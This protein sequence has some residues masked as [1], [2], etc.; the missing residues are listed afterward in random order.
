MLNIVIFGAPGSG[1]GTQSQL[2]IEKYGLHHISTGEIL[3]EEI[4]NKT[5]LG[6]I[7]DE[8]ISQGH[9]VPDQLVIDMLSNLLD[10]H[11]GV[12]GFL[13]DGFP[14]TLAQGEAL[15]VLLREKGSSVAAV[16]S[17]T[18]NEEELTQRLLKRGQDSGRSDDN[19]ETIKERLNVYRSQ[20]EPLKNYYRKNGRLFKVQGEGAVDEIFEGIMETLDHLTF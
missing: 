4:E 3:R 1:K 20:T 11:Q 14:R 16:L 15:D 8:Y 7:A 10:K 6:L 19:I 17:L 5:E 13:F 18:V 12:K 2:I 9:L